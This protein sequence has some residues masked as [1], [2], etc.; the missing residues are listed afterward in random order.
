VESIW[1]AGSSAG[2]VLRSAVSRLILRLI[3]AAA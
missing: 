3:Q 1:L 2:M